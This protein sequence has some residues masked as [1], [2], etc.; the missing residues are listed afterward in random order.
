MYYVQSFFQKVQSYWVRMANAVTDRDGKKI[1]K[2]R[3]TVSMF[4]FA[5][6]VFMLVA[7]QLSTRFVLFDQ[8]VQD[9]ENHSRHL[10]PKSDVAKPS[11]PHPPA[12]QPRA[13]LTG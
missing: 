2:K 8:G 3:T 5:T 4:F 9:S 1:L 11:V 12:R 10:S 6:T 13:P 7:L